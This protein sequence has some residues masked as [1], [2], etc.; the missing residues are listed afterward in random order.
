MTELV[1]KGAVVVLLVVI[2]VH[3]RKYMR[4]KQI[5]S[6]NKILENYMESLTM[7]CEDMERKLEATRKYRHDLVGYIQTLE[8]LLGEAKQSKE[9]KQ[10]IDEEKRKYVSYRIQESSGDEFLD[11]II[12]MKHEE[13]EKK[14]FV[15]DAEVEEGN[16]SGMEAIDKVCLFINLLGNAIEATQRLSEKERAKILLRVK[17]SEGK[18]YIYMEN[19]T[20]EELFSF[21]TKKLDAENHGLG[22]AIIQ[23]VL[24][25]YRGTRN[26]QVDKKTHLVKDEICLVLE[27]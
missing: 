24:E 26:F 7:L 6:E 8:S 25:K 21:R 11:S 27:A 12:K 13:C 4:A 10:Y 23:Q 3:L 19:A 20:T 16:Y 5:A 9:I 15:L 2:I 14:G 18:L 22:T 17:E 1:V